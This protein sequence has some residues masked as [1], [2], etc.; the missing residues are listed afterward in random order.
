MISMKTSDT[1][2]KK[3]RIPAFLAFALLISYP[4][5]ASSAPL[6]LEAAKA[7]A[8][9]GD[10]H[11]QAVVAMHY[12]LGWQVPKNPELAF[13]YAKQSAAAGDALGFYRLGALL[14]SGEGVPKDEEEG[15]RLQARAIQ[16]WNGPQQK[17]LADSDPYSLLAVGI[18][19]F[20][21][22]LLDGDK[23]ERQRIAAELYRQAA[24]SGFAPAKFNYAMC[25]WEGHGVPKDRAAAE[26]LVAESAAD[27][28]PPAIKW[29]EDQGKPVSSDAVAN[30]S[31][32]P[33]QASTTDEETVTNEAGNLSTK[34]ST[35]PANAVPIR[36]FD[37]YKKLADEGDAAAQAVVAWHYEIG[38]PVERNLAQA[39][40]YA[41]KSAD[42]GNPL[43][44][45]RF[46]YLEAMDSNNPH[47]GADFKRRALNGLVELAEKSHDPHALAILG[48]MFFYGDEVPENKEQAIACVRA[49]A[50]Q[51]FAPAQHQIAVWAREGIGMPANE[52][53]F[54]DYAKK[55]AAQDYQPSIDLLEFSERVESDGL[56][57][58][59]TGD[60]KNITNVKSIL[61]LLPNIVRDPI[62]LG[63]LTLAPI[64]T[65][66]YRYADSKFERVQLTKA[67]Y[68]KS[69]TSLFGNQTLPTIRTLK[70]DHELFTK[71][72]RIPE[73][74][75]I[76]PEA[77]R[78]IANEIADEDS[79][80]ISDSP[81]YLASGSGQSGS[82]LSCA[83][84]LILVDNWDEPA[85]FI[86]ASIIAKAK[87]FSLVGN[88]IENR[89]GGYEG[90]EAFRI[91]CDD[92]EEFT[93]PPHNSFGGLLRGM[94]PGTDSPLAKLAVAFNYQ[95]ALHNLSI[96]QKFADA[97]APKPQPDAPRFLGYTGIRFGMPQRE[98][99]DLLRNV[100]DYHTF[101]PVETLNC[102]DPEDMKSIDGDDA[103]NYLRDLQIASNGLTLV[104]PWTIATIRPRA[105]AE[106]SEHTRP[107][108]VFI[109]KENRLV[110]IG[111][112]PNTKGS[113]SSRMGYPEF[114]DDQR[115]P[116]D[117]SQ[118]NVMLEKYG[119][120]FALSAVFQGPNNSN[121]ETFQFLWA[122]E[123]P[124]RV[125]GVFELNRGKFAPLPT[126]LK[127]AD[128]I[129][130]LSNTTLVQSRGHVVPI[131]GRELD[132]STARNELS[133]LRC[134]YYWD[135]DSAELLEKTASAHM[136]GLIEKQQEIEKSK[137]QKITDEL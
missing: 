57:K 115:A 128:R 45:A 26:T 14:R 1:L 44:L 5:C 27:S 90:V 56:A 13:E 12:S 64:D 20:Q 86:P 52:S 121:P 49:S 62:L 104:P 87:S 33:Q 18:L 37:E 17:R 53:V 6:S 111:R 81:A 22:K 88:N 76:S 70:Q 3:N 72:S 99:L 131:D 71:V 21:G 67:D 39:E 24:E 29:L 91:H 43:G 116:K 48:M 96:L 38:W 105:S 84:G 122:S 59:G 74:N 69:V 34:F 85:A 129:R 60:S 16:E 125:G 66:I 130:N 120:P 114:S 93:F 124:V 15:L 11:A 134:A 30:V 28:Y 108:D 63:R 40:A 82:W 36:S 119:E 65:T 73:L 83:N 7:A 31:N 101:H 42:Q 118:L 61:T 35:P 132:F 32:V 106:G 47:V 102:I 98:C 117:H 100:V 2:H 110:A 133:S 103:M 123:D 78:R 92:G 126:N 135:A 136:A 79:Q 8:E 41:K 77:S 97:I 46:G 75:Y 10:S 68:I 109:F 113:K 80:F 89:Y 55:A 19:Y 25:L 95:K 58:A 23:D 4:V 112:Y 137:I 107:T 9:S 51:G 50:D 54:R 94:S 127:A